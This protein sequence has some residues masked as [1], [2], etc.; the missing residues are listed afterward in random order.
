MHCNDTFQYVIAEAF[1]QCTQPILKNSKDSKKY[2]EVTTKCITL[3]LEDLSWMSSKTS[4]QQFICWNI[5]NSSCPAIVQ[6]FFENLEWL[7]TDG[8]SIIAKNLC[9]IYMEHRNREELQS[10]EAKR[11]GKKLLAIVYHDKCIK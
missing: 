7:S 6:G 2:M 1:V 9:K 4:P 8:S 10:A 11:Y 5:I 3:I